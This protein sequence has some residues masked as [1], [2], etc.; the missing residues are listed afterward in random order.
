ML[1]S[2]ENK[3]SEKITMPIAERKRMLTA[4]LILGSLV[5]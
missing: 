5:A 2:N 1:Q 4:L 3:V